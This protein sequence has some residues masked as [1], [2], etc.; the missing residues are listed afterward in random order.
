MDHHRL[1]GALGAAIHPDHLAR[2]G[3][4]VQH[5]RRLAVLEHQRFCGRVEPQPDPSLELLPIF[6]LLRSL[7]LLGWIDARPELDH[8]ELFAEVRALARRQSA[9]LLG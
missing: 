7:A 8:G 2:S 9:T 1:Q 6:L 5:A 4:R 3:R